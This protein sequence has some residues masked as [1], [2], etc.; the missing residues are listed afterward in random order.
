MKMKASLSGRLNADL[1]GNKN[2]SDF[3]IEDICCE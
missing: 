1:I 3:E 2:R